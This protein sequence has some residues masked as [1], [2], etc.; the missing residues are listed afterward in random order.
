MRT[1]TRNTSF[2]SRLRACLTAPLRWLKL[3][4]KDA[5]SRAMRHELLLSVM[6]IAVFSGIVLMHDY[7]PQPQEPLVATFVKSMTVWLN[8]IS[9]AWFM[10]A[11]LFMSSR[12][13]WLQCFWGACPSPLA[14]NVFRHLRRIT[15]F[16]CCGQAL[17]LGFLAFGDDIIRAGAEEQAVMLALLPVLLAITVSRPLFGRYGV[18]TAI[19]GNDSREANDADARFA[20]ISAQLTEQLR[21][22]DAVIVDSWYLRSTAAHEAGHMLVCAALHDTP[23]DITLHLEMRGDTAG[24]IKPGFGVDLN[25]PRFCNDPVCIHWLMLLLQA[26][27]VA[28]RY[29]TGRDGFG[30]SNDNRHWLSCAQIYLA[31]LCEDTIYYADPNNEQEQAHNVRE[32][33]ALKQQQRALLATFFDLNDAVLRDLSAAAQ[34]KRTLRR[35]DLLPFF[36]RVRF[37]EGF[38]RPDLAALAE[39]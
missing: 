21:R 6:A 5:A 17:S 14:V 34:E 2:L 33:N 31:N 10:G 13:L 39:G 15:L 4:G 36:A 30:A 7:L 18:S 9:L 24:Y 23:Q 11:A 20:A 25:A 26:G 12:E 16:Q 32:L 27:A 22:H 8:I 1:L 28:E 38:P 37:P 29:L 3:D 19:T 35:D